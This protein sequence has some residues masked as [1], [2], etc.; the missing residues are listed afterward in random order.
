MQV[1]SFAWGV[2][3]VIAM[4]IA[5]FPCLGALNWI[6]VPFSAIG[7]IVSFMTYKN[8]KPGS[9]NR[10]AYFG[11]MFCLISVF[12]GLLRLIIGAGIF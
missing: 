2:L 7:F 8:T 4:I 9:P 10:P 1:I 5:F 3:S 12:G 11:W 6:V